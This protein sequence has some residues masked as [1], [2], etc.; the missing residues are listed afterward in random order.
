MLVKDEK[1]RNLILNG[2]MWKVIVAICAPLFIYNLF[3]SLYNLVDSV[4]AN[5]ISTD[6]VSSVAALGQIKN[7]LSSFGSGLAAGGAIIVARYFGAGDFDKARK[8][9]NVLVTL[10][11]VVVAALAVICIPLAYPICKAS[12][13]SQAQAAASTG[14]FI[15][16]IIELL[17]IAYNNVFIALQKSKGNTKSI[18]YLNFVTMGV[19][20]VLNVIFIYA[21]HVDSIIWIAVATLISQITLFVILG[22]MMIKKN[23]IFR[24]KFKEFSLSWK[25]V[26]PILILSIPIFLGKFVFSFGKVAVNSIFGSRY[27]EILKSQID[28]TDEVAVKA[29]EAS[30]GLVV[31]ALAVSNSLNGIAT[32]PINSFEETESTIISQNL[33]NHNLKRA[34]ECFIKG[35]IMATILGFVSWIFIRFIFQDALIGLYSRDQNPEQAEEFKQYVKLIH[36]Y[37]SWS[38]PSLAIN[39]GVLGVLYGF[40]KTKLTMMINIARAFVF[41]IPI[42]VILLYCFPQLGVEC[43]GLSMGISNI[44]I[45]VLSIICLLIFLIQIKKKGYQGM[46]LTENTGTGTANLQVEENEDSKETVDQEEKDST[47]DLETIT[48]DS[49][50]EE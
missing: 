22:I 24:I 39:G 16:Q 36:N 44:C 4:F 8:N 28:I 12:G 20:L 47:E 31:G 37:D 21:L 46:T 14:Y 1:R 26:K 30:A 48:E 7:L 33:G 40:G 19:K 15:I 5:E 13:I 50:Q 29:A 32:T 9:A 6:S 10:V 2:N 27:L 49:N 18:F 43:A 3:N 25:Y 11:S 45:A 17:F 35:F 34:I 23:N 41:R 42:L 38:I